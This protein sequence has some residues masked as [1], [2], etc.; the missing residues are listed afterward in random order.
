[1][2]CTSKSLSNFWGAYQGAA[3]IYLLLLMFVRVRM[4]MQ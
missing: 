1:M 4:S 2:I 3:A